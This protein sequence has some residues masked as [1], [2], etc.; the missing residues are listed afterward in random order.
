[1]ISTF[2]YDNLLFK[3]IYNPSLEKYLSSVFAI[4]RIRLTLMKTKKK[5]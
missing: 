2:I 3:I 5:C 4:T 1:M